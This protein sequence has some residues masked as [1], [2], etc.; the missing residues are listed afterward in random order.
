MANALN[1]FVLVI[2]TV[3]AAVPTLLYTFIVWRLDRYEREP[4]KLLV[5]TFLW[6]AAPAVIASIFLE[7]LT[8]AP[9]DTAPEEVAKLV[10][11]SFIAP[12]VEEFFKAMALFSLYLLYR[13]E[14]DGVLDG[15]IYGSIV[16]F[17]F[18]MT[19]NVLYFVNAWRAGGASQW[20]SLVLARSVVFGLNHAMFTSFTGI[21]LGVARMQ[22][23]R[24]TRLVVVFIGYALA[25]AVHMFHN[26]FVSAGNACL[27]SLLA[28]WAGVLVLL[29]L[30]VLAW[31]RE[32]TYMRE[33]L[34]EEVD[35]GILTP[36]QLDT[37]VSHRRRIKKQ[38]SLLGISQRQ[39]ARVWRELAQVATELAFKKHQRAVMGE[40]RQNGELVARLR[41][42]ILTLRQQLGEQVLIAGNLC[43][44][45]GVLLP[46]A[47]WQTCPNCGHARE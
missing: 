42:R 46:D 1:P 23:S 32:R 18:A 22:K 13:Q 16:G 30:V 21:G 12:P 6:G 24:G 19:E 20:G 9:L 43:G 47:A 34:A 40:E 3:A 26:F 14:F 17:G 15:I 33:Q 11:A 45:C 5:A 39:Q 4:V 8:S 41:R 31:R 25:V 29:V 37:F 36:L 10:S 38:W 2:S 7:I 28:D 35:L 27:L 44:Y